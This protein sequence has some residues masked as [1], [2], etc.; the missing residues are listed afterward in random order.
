MIR[1]MYNG[2]YYRILQVAEVGD[3][4]IDEARSFEETLVPSVSVSVFALLP[5]TTLNTTVM[6]YTLRKLNS[7]L[8]TIKL[9]TY[10]CALGLQCSDVCCTSILSRLKQQV[11]ILLFILLNRFKLNN[12]IH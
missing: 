11:Q 7:T 3:V 9:H 10:P 8:E 6:F 1:D 4:L 5:H 12:L 2:S